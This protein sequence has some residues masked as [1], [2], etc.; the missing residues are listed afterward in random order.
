MSLQTLISNVLTSPIK[1]VVD[2]I[3]RLKTQVLSVEGIFTANH[4]ATFTEAGEDG[5]TILLVSAVGKDAVN[6]LDMAKNCTPSESVRVWAMVGDLLQ[7]NSID[8][9][10]ADG[11]P[12]E[13]FLAK[14]VQLA[15]EGGELP[16]AV[17]KIAADFQVTL[18]PDGSVTT[19]D[20]P[21]AE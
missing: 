18:N 7:G 6:T 20:L 10:I 4:A 11:T 19:A 21:E 8:T 16:E 14:S 13:L 17:R 2:S 12:K 1:R 5:A 15:Y 9:T 3:E